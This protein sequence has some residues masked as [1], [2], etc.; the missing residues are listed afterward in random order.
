APVYQSAA[1]VLVV[2][3]RADA[4]PIQGLET[5]QAYYDDYVSVHIV[6]IKSPLIIARAVKNGE[7]Q[8]L[9][10]FEGCSDPVGPIIAGLTVARDSKDS[11]SYG[12]SSNILNLSFRGPVADECDVVLNAVVESYQSFLDETYR[13][14]SHE[15]VNLIN[16]AKNV[17][18]DDLAR[19]KKTYK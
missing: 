4:L 16:S 10:S 3:K 8:K 18:H 13:N 12:N 9:K 2:K 6:L 1:Q 11:Y 5:S 19:A 14:L 15:A 17:L 7:L